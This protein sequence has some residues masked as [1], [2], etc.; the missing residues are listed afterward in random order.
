MTAW[1]AGCGTDA[2][3]LQTHVDLST[4]ADSDKLTIIIITLPGE[5][6]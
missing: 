3:D 4:D 1:G 2:L 6:S 5:G